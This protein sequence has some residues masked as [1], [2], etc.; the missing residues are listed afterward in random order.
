MTGQSHNKHSTIR[1]LS[2]SAVILDGF[3]PLVKQL[4]VVLLFAIAILVSLIVPTAR[5]TSVPALIAATVL[6]AVATGLAGFL[7]RMG[8]GERAVASLVCYS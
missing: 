6:L 5:I 8:L 4:P 7:P 1:A 2:I 3:P